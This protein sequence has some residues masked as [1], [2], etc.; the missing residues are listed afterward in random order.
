MFDGLLQDWTTIAGDGPGPITQSAHAWAELD[1]FSNVT[2]WLEVREVDSASGGTVTISYETSPTADESA[3]RQIGAVALA[4]TSTPTITKIRLGDDPQVAL[5]K[6]LR[7]SL[8]GPATGLWKTCFRVFASGTRGLEGPRGIPGDTSGLRLTLTSAT[9]V[10]TTDVTGTTLYFT[11]F[12]HAQ[13]VLF[14]GTI[15]DGF[16]TDEVSLAG[17]L[18]LSSVYDIFAY[19]DPV[20]NAVTLEESTAWTNDTTRADSVVRKDGVFVKSSDPTRRLVG[21]VRTDANGHFVDT[22]LQRWVW[23]ANNRIER[24]LFRTDTATSWLYSGSAWRAANN[25]TAN[26]ISYVD[27][28]G[29]DVVSAT[30]AGA[31]RSGDTSP[32]IGY[33]GIGLDSSTTISAQLRGS[34]SSAST[35][36]Q[37]QT[38]AVYNGYPGI[39]VHSLYWIERADGTHN[40]V[41]SSQP[42]ADYQF[43]IIG[44]VK[45]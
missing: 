31:T 13:I 7:W 21:T 29:E 40:V 25:N 33:F 44:T 17:P 26:V 9:P 41:F 5:G 2:F 35:G 34:D 3:F 36:P 22:V 39:G 45:A 28:A 15:W 8:Q 11:P 43:G 6:Y 18:T 32:R 42:G 30:A 14:N 1:D 24:P 20:T 38:P 27:G 19:Y 37:L 16:T 12:R 10:T 23:N 4:I